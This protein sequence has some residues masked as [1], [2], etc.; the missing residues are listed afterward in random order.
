MF[1]NIPCILFATT[2]TKCSSGGKFVFHD[3]LCGCVMQFILYQLFLKYG[4]MFL[5]HVLACLLLLI[6][7]KFW[8]VTSINCLAE[9]PPENETNGYIFIH[10]EGGL[11]QQRIAVWFLCIPVINWLRFVFPLN[12]LLPYHH[13][14]CLARRFRI[15]SSSFARYVMQLL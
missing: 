7:L 1:P 11:N 8:V 14:Y 9:L 12:V 10:A 13:V 4:Y 6:L 5:F 3:I 15:T 2:N